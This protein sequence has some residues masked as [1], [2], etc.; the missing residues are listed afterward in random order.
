MD[1]SGIGFWLVVLAGCGAGSHPVGDDDDVG[2]SDGDADSDP[3]GE[4][5][6]EGGEGEE[7]DLGPDARPSDYPEAGDWRDADPSALGEGDPCC[8]LVGDPVVLDGP[9]GTGGPPVVEWN[10][11]GW[12]VAWPAGFRSLDPLGEPLG[13]MVSIAGASRYTS[14]ALNWGNGRYA[15]A[16]TASEWPTRRAEVLMLDADGRIL[17]GPTDLGAELDEPDIA[18]QSHGHGW[19]IVYNVDDEGERG[20]VLANWVEDDATLGGEPRQVGSGFG[21][22]VV[23]L[24]SRTSVA[25]LQTDGVWHRSFAWPEVEDAAPPARVIEMGAYED[26]SIEAVAYRDLTVVAAMDGG[27]VLVVL[28]DP[29][30]AETVAGPNAVAVSSLSDRRPG[31]AAVDERGYLGL[32][33]AAGSGTEEEGISFVLVGPDATA[34][35]EAVPVVE[36]LRSAFGCAVGWSGEEFLVAWVEAALEDNR[37]LAQRVVPRI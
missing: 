1:R 32:C 26:S 20:D 7:L 12:G 16:A 14:V 34:W 18:R 22:R 35:G 13:T 36:H 28:V 5:E 24:R 27:D 23:G 10:G 37:I 9:G 21:A 2:A 30:T 6:G 19:V 25:W 4:G 3:G 8:E 29:W 15:V 11:G 17:V 31:A 33:Y